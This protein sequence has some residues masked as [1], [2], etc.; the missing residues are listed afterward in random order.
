VSYLGIQEAAKQMF[1]DIGSLKE[2][3]GSVNVPDDEAL[4]KAKVL[5][6]VIETYWAFER[7]LRWRAAD[8]LSLLTRSS[9]PVCGLVMERGRHYAEILREHDASPWNPNLI[10]VLAKGPRCTEVRDFLMDLIETFPGMA[11]SDACSA[12]VEIN[13]GL[14]R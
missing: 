3:A 4:R 9:A 2:D 8:Y 5:I 14:G 13:A 11:S 6:D 7:A 10:N 12:L 1:L